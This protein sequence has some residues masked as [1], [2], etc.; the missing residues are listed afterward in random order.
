MHAVRPSL[1]RELTR[2]SV[3][4]GDL[5]PP[6]LLDASLIKLDLKMF[7]SFGVFYME[8]KKYFLLI[9]GSLSLL[10]PESSDQDNE[11]G[12][13]EQEQAGGTLLWKRWE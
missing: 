8:G 3:L 13:C 11:L 2:T 5:L 12:V 6:C 10:S 4:L 9:G 1:N 7:T